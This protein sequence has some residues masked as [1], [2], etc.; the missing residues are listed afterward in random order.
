MEGL[1]DQSLA[2][3]VGVSNYRVSDLQPLLASARIKVWSSVCACVCARV[4][5]SVCGGEPRWGGASCSNPFEA[6]P[7]LLIPPPLS[8]HHLPCV[9]PLI[10]ESFLFFMA[11]C[12]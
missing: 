9:F 3:E 8:L 2:R 7:V 12:L 5:M 11:F 4:R 6:H 1:V 10:P